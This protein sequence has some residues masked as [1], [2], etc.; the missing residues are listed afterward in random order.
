MN[1]PGQVVF[2][3][4]SETENGSACPIVFSEDIQKAPLLKDWILGPRRR[5]APLSL[6]SN[7]FSLPAEFKKRGNRVGNHQAIERI[8]VGVGGGGRQNTFLF[9]SK[10]SPHLEE[11]QVVDAIFFWP[12]L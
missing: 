8:G 2:E 12:F 10:D 5:F 9:E 7:G 6:D 3:W 1:Q 11:S 4:G